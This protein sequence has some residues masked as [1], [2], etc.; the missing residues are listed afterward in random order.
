MMGTLCVPRAKPKKYQGA[1]KKLNIRVQIKWVKNYS[2]AQKCTFVL[3][4]INNISRKKIK[5][6]M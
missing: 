1:P 5:K 4:S 6:L 3:I 2:F